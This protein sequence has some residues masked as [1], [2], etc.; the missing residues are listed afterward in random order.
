MDERNSAFFLFLPWNYF[1]QL[2]AIWLRSQLKTLLEHLY[3]FKH[4]R[5]SNIKGA[6]FELSHY[7]FLPVKLNTQIIYFQFKEFYV[8]FMT[9]QSTGFKFFAKIMTGSCIFCCSSCIS[10]NPASH[11]NDCFCYC[12]VWNMWCVERFGTISAI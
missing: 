4:K 11:L 5:K 7:S 8:P 6:I 1:V 10:F 2:W 9:L 12:K 3:I